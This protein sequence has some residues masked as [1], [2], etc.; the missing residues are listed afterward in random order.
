[1]HSLEYLGPILGA[2]TFSITKISIMTLSIKAY[3]QHSEKMTL[4][5]TVL[6]SIMLCVAIFIVMLN[7]IMLNV[8]MLNVIIL[9][10]VDPYFG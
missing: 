10:V 4:S 9:N 6:S 5:I 8:V 2:T 3:L 1:M 7:V